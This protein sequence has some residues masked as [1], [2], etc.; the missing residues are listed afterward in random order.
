MLPSI[1]RASQFLQLHD[2]PLSTVAGF[3]HSRVRAWMS[4]KA[5]VVFSDEGGCDAIRSVA[6]DEFVAARSVG[7]ACTSIG[8]LEFTIASRSLSSE[9]L[10][11]HRGHGQNARNPTIAM[12]TRL[13]AAA[14]APAAGL[15]RLK[16]R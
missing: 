15:H 12:T 2:A 9:L 6:V 10:G 4:E 5:I 8:L 14:S 16:A 7:V 3:P 13:E 1:A 11:P